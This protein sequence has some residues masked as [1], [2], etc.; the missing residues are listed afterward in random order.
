MFNTIVNMYNYFFKSQV[1]FINNSL[2]IKIYFY[3]NK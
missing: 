2:Y 3:Y 1:L